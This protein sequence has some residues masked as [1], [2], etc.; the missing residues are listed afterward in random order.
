VHAARASGRRLQ[1]PGCGGPDRDYAASGRLGP[2]DQVRRCGGNVGPL[3]IHR[4][5]VELGAAHRQ[6]R[7][8]TDMQGECGNRDATRA[9]RVQ[10]AG[11]EMETRRRCGDGPRCSGVHG[12]VAI[13]IEGEGTVRTLDVRRQRYLS[14]PLEKGPDSVSVREG[15]LVTAVSQHR[16]DL[17]SCLIGKA[18]LFTPPQPAGRSAEAEPGVC[19]RASCVVGR[20]RSGLGADGF[21]APDKQQLDRSASSGC[22]RRCAR[23]SR[24][25]R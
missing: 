25:C 10:Q 21:D 1:R 22:A 19:R 15:D 2:L 20:R 12:L 11:G 8:G 6:E 7:S 18:N 24:G 5:G 14:M 17:C 23:E 4:V 13:P 9:H 16:G 3:R